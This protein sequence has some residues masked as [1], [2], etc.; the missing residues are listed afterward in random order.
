ML[1]QASI[2]QIRRQEIPR[3]NSHLVIAMAYHPRGIKKEWRDDYRGELA[4]DR[5]LFK[6]WKEH[7][8]KYGHAEAFAR[9]NY[10][11]RF[12]PSPLALFHLQE[13]IRLAE[14]K[15]VYLIC[16]CQMGERCH[17]EML[18]LIAR[19]KYGAKTDKIFHDY[20]TLEKRIPA[21]DD[22]LKLW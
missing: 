7:E 21:L 8:Q 11:E 3:A 20:P 13:Y 4:P 16:Q 10:E 18:L 2:E 9:S 14:E 15:D 17:R 5:E 6:D 1:K 19:K 22:Q 12:T